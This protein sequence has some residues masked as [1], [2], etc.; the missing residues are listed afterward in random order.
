MDIQWVA[1]SPDGTQAAYVAADQGN[2]DIWIAEPARG[3]RTRLTFAPEADTFPVWSPSGK[4][5][6]FASQRNGNFDVFVRAANG[7]GEPRPAVV[8]PESEY[9]DAWSPDGTTLLINRVSPRTSNDLWMVKQKAD[10]TFAPPTVWLQTAHNE[11]HATFSPDGKYVAYDSDDSG[12]LETYVRPVGG[13]GKW[14]ISAV[15]GS[16]PRWSR[17]GREIFYTQGESLM[18]TPVSVGGG[19]LRPGTPV[20]LFRNRSFTDTVRVWDVHPDG[21]RFLVGEDDEADAKPASIHVILNW[22]ALLREKGPQ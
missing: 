10:G 21:K 12:R 6:A 13:D 2:V 17:D 4:Q 19:T 18:A 1:L 16:N 14:Q 15:G 3:L 11:T 7:V 22:P 5:I 20:E 8:S 9:P